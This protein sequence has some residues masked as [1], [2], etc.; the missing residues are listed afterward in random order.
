MPPKDDLIFWAKRWNAARQ[1]YRYIPRQ[2][3]M[4]LCN[5]N[6]M[7]YLVEVFSYLF[8]RRI[9]NARNRA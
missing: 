8:D 3:R 1:I 2:R 9:I 5:M 7:L 4:T 6:Q